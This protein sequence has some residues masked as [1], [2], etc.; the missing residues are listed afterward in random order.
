MRCSTRCDRAALPLAVGQYSALLHL[1]LDG[2]AAGLVWAHLLWVL[3]YMVLTLIGAYRAF[4]VRLVTTARALGHTHLSACLFVQ[5]PTLAST[6]CS[7]HSPSVFGEHR[8][9][10]RRLC[11][12]AADSF[13]TV[14]TGPL[15]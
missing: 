6:T 8:A 5:W 3:P 9:I 10:P 14:T 12:Q 11:S 4:D 1:N 15:P 2:T 13:A 7:R